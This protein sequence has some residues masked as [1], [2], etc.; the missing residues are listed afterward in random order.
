[1]KFFGRL[2][3]KYNEVE[4]KI[5]IARI[6]KKTIDIE[7]IEYIFNHCDPNSKPE[8]LRKKIM[9]VINDEERFMKRVN[10]WMSIIHKD[11]K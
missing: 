8:H 1:M 6:L 10:C 7:D 3:K 4:I 5:S 11:K 9:S 2:F